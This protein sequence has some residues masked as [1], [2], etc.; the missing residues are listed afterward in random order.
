MT[1]ELIKVIDGKHETVETAFLKKDVD[2]NDGYNYLCI[3]VDG[4]N[5]VL[6]MGKNKLKE[7]LHHKMTDNEKKLIQGH[8][9]LRV[10]YMVGQ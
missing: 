10:G 3:Q 9:A 4:E 6:A 8:D 7:I 2:L 1:V 5:I